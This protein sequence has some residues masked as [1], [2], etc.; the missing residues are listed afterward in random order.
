M[1]IAMIGHKRVPSREGGIEVAVGALAVRMAKRGHDVTVY[2]RR[3]K[4]I[5][6]KVYN[7][8][9]AKNDLFDGV[10]IKKVPA[11][12][13]KG[14]AA[15]TS[16]FFA[17]VCALFGKYDC[18]HYHGEGPAWMLWIPHLFGIKTVVTIHGLDWQ[19]SKWNA[20]AS[21]VLRKGEKMAVRYAD[22]MIVL[23]KETQEYFIKEYK[24]DT[25]CI[26][27]GTDKLSFRKA[28]LICD[29]WNLER[30]SYILFL[31]RIVPEKGIHYLIEAFKKLN[32]DIKLVIAG[33]PSDTQE[34]YGQLIKMAEDDRIVFTGFVQGQ[35]LEELYSNAYL[36]CL[37]SDLEGM[38]ISLLEAMRYGLGC[39]T[40]DI[41]ECK[42]VLN[43]LGWTFPKGNV[44]ELQ[45]VLQQLCDNPALITKIR[46]DTEEYSRRFDWEHV[47]DRTLEVYEE[48]QK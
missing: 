39:V 42:N 8:T 12:D 17:T 27:N 16:S 47:T 36:Y 45:K 32:T 40:S 24:R 20:L 6:G 5:A 34:Y 7:N 22:A 21:W 19:R 29:K 33:S 2:N 14:L 15:L 30:N 3:G 37:P 43:N 4:H 1:K 38:P 23:N 25:I 18:I 11:I 28:E 31:G 35:E 44:E 13:F 9:E 26:P 10:R 48:V 46:K 41:P